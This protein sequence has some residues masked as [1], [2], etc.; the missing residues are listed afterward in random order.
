MKNGWPQKTLGEVCEI[1]GGGTPSKSVE[2]YWI[3]DIPWVSPKDVK[4]ATVSD[5]IDHISREAIDN[6]ATS[7]IPENSVLMVVRSGILARTVPLAVAG[8]ALTINQD[9]KAL[10]PNDKVSARFLYHLLQS[11][12][13][14]LLAMVSRGATVHRLMTE[15][16]R[17]LPFFLPPPAEQQRLV[18]VLDEALAGYATA[19]AHAEKNLQNARALFE[20][21]LESLFVQRGEGWVERRLGDVVTRLTNG[22]VGPTRDIYRKSGIPYLLA[23][24]VKNNRLVFDGKTFVSD[25]FNRKNKKSILKSGDVLLVQ[26]GHIGHAA[27]VP[28]EHEGHNCHAMIV[29]TPLKEAVI[30]PFLSLYFRSSGMMRKVNEIRSGS[31]VPH[32]TCGAVKELTIPLPEVSTQRRLVEYLEDMQGETQ[33]LQ[34][35]YQQKVASLASLKKSLL[36][37]AFR[38]AL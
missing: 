23:R 31:T 17:S 30:G 22:Y 25:E 36:H 33:R 14:T 8:R 18:R 15:Q 12:M 24:H 28:P 5:S 37:Q 26:S 21:Y 38:G 19:Q 6:S 9:L 32:L 1:R 13:D 7:L 29:M 11:K 34:G 4:F 27:V 10:C 2:R 16:I 35:L 20:S 3:G